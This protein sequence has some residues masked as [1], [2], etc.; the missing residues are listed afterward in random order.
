[1]K[2]QYVA[3]LNDGARV[4]TEFVV[5]RKELRVGRSG[6][7]YLAL[8]LADR[9]G[10]LQASLF[11]RARE[12]AESFSEGDYV[13]VAGMMKRY[14]GRLELVIRTL[15]ALAGDECDALDFLPSSRRP[16]EELLG[17]LE[18][19]VEEVHERHLHALL[20]VFLKDESFM[21]RFTRAPA[22]KSYHHAYLGGL[23]E[24]TVSV[25][26]MCEHACQQYPQVDRDL[27]VTAAILHDVG[28][29]EEF[30]YDSR[31]DYTDEGRFVGHLIMGERM[32]TERLRRIKGFPEDVGL[33]LRHAILSH[34]GELEWG[35]PKRPSTLEA[36][37]LHHVDN[38]DAKVA[39]FGEIVHRYA[40]P[41][42]KWTDVQNL[43]RRPLYV[44]RS[45]EDE[46]RVA[47]EGDEYH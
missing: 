44:P 26:T 45:V 43:F 41:D 37:I 17:Y 28:K 14:R 39:G 2:K 16:V 30:E 4:E 8:E 32:L 46:S 47:E 18:F 15:V 42:V 34:H 31:I 3:G 11:S 1:M 38:L 23:L 24:H 12:T 29:I 6:E 7:P 20:T 40:G 35:S 19:L 10:F 21:S 25:A 9:T 22:A 5:C 33:R 13:R 27:L 36:L